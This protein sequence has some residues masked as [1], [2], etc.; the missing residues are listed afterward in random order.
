MLDHRKL[1]P[2]ILLK[3]I[4]RA[5]VDFDDLRATSGRK[6]SESCRAVC[7]AIILSGESSWRTPISQRATALLLWDMGVSHRKIDTLVKVDRDDIRKWNQRLFSQGPLGLTHARRSK[8]GDAIHS[9]YER[10]K[11]L[12]PKPVELWDDCDDVIKEL[13][14]EGQ[15]SHQPRLL[16]FTNPILRQH[17]Q[18]FRYMEVDSVVWKERRGVT[19]LESDVHWEALDRIWDRKRERRLWQARLVRDRHPHGALLKVYRRGSYASVEVEVFSVGRLICRGEYPH[20]PI[21]LAEVEELLRELQFELS[22][23]FKVTPNT[24]PISLKNDTPFQIHLALDIPQSPV[25]QVELLPYIQTERLVF[26]ED[27]NRDEEYGTRCALFHWPPSNPA[28]KLLVYDKGL[29]LLDDQAARPSDP[30]TGSFV[31]ANQVARW[32]IRL[33]PRRAKCVEWLRDAGMRW[34]MGKPILS[35]FLQEEELAHRFLRK[36][37]EENFPM[38][39]NCASYLEFL[40]AARLNPRIFDYVAE[41]VEYGNRR[42]VHKHGTFSA[43]KSREYENKLLQETGKNPPNLVWGMLRHTHLFASNFI[44]A[45]EGG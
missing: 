26:N 6:I 5:H 36:I 7:R 16:P 4:E 39:N 35:D 30:L 21:S 11:S 9:R 24:P 8:I 20:R 28:L 27:Y 41:L 2:K 33:F 42:S 12:A 40:M 38:Y 1:W 34:G 22:K 32:E 25:S 43:A 15:H 37:I 3:H 45:V 13:K 14:E 44:A 31:N 23:F 29:R 17:Q 19:I 18:W 10:K